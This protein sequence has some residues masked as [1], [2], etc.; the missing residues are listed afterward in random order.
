MFILETRNCLCNL[1]WELTNYKRCFIS[2]NSKL[3]QTGRTSLH[4][5]ARHGVNECVSILLRNGSDVEAQDKNGATPLALA[6][7]QNHCGVVK[8][9][10]DSGSKTN[11]LE[12]KIRIKVDTCLK[13][14]NE[15][16]GDNLRYQANRQSELLIFKRI[17]LLSNYIIFN[18]SMEK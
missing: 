1:G 8:T 4:I 17:I 7:W 9:L 10:V 14:F 13:H 11:N 16:V 5:A 15:S 3:P 6:A 12:E 18:P 2:V